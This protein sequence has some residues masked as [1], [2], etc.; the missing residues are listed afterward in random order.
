[1]LG[2]FYE[3]YGQH[4]VWLKLQKTHT[5]RKSTLHEELGI[6]KSISRHLREKYNKHGTAREADKTVNHLNILLRHV[7]AI[8]K[9]R[10]RGKDSKAPQCYTTLTFPSLLLF[11]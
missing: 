5:H 11:R 7:D 4:S 3:I 8:C 9:L 1:M 10:K 2:I 6:F